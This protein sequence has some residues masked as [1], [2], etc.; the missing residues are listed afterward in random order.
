[1][2][3][4]WKGTEA[5]GPDWIDAA[6]VMVLVVVVVADVVVSGIESLGESARGGGCCAWAWWALTGLRWVLPYKAPRGGSIVEDDNRHPFV[7]PADDLDDPLCRHCIHD[8]VLL[9]FD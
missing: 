4:R 1:M 8:I 2:Q 3:T 6:E 9:I 5:R 7:W